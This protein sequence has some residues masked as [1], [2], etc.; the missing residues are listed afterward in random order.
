MPVVSDDGGSTQ[1][2]GMISRD[3][4]LRVMQARAELGQVNAAGS[5]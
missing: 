1:I 2:V 5:R 4:I 3:S